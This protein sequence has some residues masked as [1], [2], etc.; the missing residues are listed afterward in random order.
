MPLDE[1]VLNWLEEG[2]FEAE[3]AAE[4]TDVALKCRETGKRGKVS[5][6]ISVE[7]K[8]THA[9]DL[10]T[11]IDSRAP[12]PDRRRTRLYMDDDGHLSRRDPRQLV[13]EG[14]REA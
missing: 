11:Q 3:L 6:T 12:R 10:D 1:S 7:A 4:L 13:L 9:L 2:D 8:G 5:V 14:L